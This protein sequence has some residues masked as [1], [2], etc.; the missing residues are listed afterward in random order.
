MLCTNSE[1][2]YNIVHIWPDSDVGIKTRQLQRPSSVIEES[3]KAFG[4]HHK[5]RFA[6]PFA[7]L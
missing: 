7:Y 6:C 5:L 4:G 2:V 1:K 3:R